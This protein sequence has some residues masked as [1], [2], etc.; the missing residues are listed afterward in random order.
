MAASSSSQVARSRG[1]APATT[2]AAERFR[3]RR[4]QGSANTRRATAADL[5][6]FEEYCAAHNF[7]PYPAAVATLSNYVAHLAELPRKLA[8]IQRHLASIQRQHRLRKLKSAAGTP[9]LLDVMQGIALDLGT[10]Q[11]QAPAFSVD[12]LKSCIQKL[13]LSTTAG[14]RDRA[15]LLLGFTGAFRRSELVAIDLEQ[16]EVD[17]QGMLIRLGRTKT[18]QTGAAEEK[19]FFYSENALFCPIRAYQDWLRQLGGRTTGPLFVR[20][21][22]SRVAGMGTPT[23][24]RLSDKSVNTL[25]GQHLGSDSNG[26]RYT[27]HSFRSSFITTAK[28]AGQSNDFIRNQTNHKTDAILAR[29]TR[30]TDKV[31]YNAGKALGL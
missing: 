21:A 14:L 3:G 25:V 5:R 28:L 12:Y 7:K 16:I 6:S 30:L 26:Q 13:D 10:K 8:T 24:Q 22:R 23:T 9:E 20:I 1:E 29:Y 31:A 11:K 15:L 17:S 27:A 2:A 4:Q 19:A 18:N